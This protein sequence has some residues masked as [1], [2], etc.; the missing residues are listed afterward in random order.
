MLMSNDN[1]VYVNASDV[2]RIHNGLSDTAK[3]PIDNLCVGKDINAYKLFS[4]AIIRYKKYHFFLSE[5]RDGYE[6]EEQLLQVQLV[7][8][9]VDELSVNKSFLNALKRKLNIVGITEELVESISLKGMKRSTREDGVSEI[10]AVFEIFLTVKTNTTET[11]D[12]SSSWLHEIEI[13]KTRKIEAET[14][15]IYQHWLKGSI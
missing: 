15:V 10:G 1:V 12:I 13:D 8:E 14:R 6:S 5:K 4:Y 2:E 11:L 9:D 3:M 7:P